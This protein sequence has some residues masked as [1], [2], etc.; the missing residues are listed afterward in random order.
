MHHAALL[1]GQASWWAPPHTVFVPLPGAGPDRPWRQL[2]L[3]V[4]VGALS[5]ILVM[6]GV[7]SGLDAC[8]AIG[9][10]GLVIAAVAAL[11]GLASLSAVTSAARAARRISGDLGATFF[12][13]ND[14]D[15]LLRQAT[16][17]AIASQG[18][19]DSAGILQRRWLRAFQRLPRPVP[20]LLAERFRAAVRRPQGEPEGPLLQA[21]G[22][23]GTLVGGMAAG[24]LVLVPASLIF[25]VSMGAGGGAGA[26]IAGAVVALAPLLIGVGLLAG[27]LLS[28]V[29]GAG[30]VRSL[31][32]ITGGSMRIHADAVEDRRGRRWSPRDSILVIEPMTDSGKA[33]TARFV[34]P[35]GH[36]RFRLGSAASAETGRLLEAWSRWCASA[37]TEADALV[38]ARPPGAEDD[39]SIS[40]AERWLAGGVGARR[41]EEELPAAVA[42]GA[43]RDGVDDREVITATLPLLRPLGSGPLVR[44]FA[45]LMS[46]QVAVIVVMFLINP[47][48]LFTFGALCFPA[49]MLLSPTIVAV[50]RFV[51]AERDRLAGA[52]AARRILA[53]PTSDPASRAIAA[54]LESTPTF[55]SNR[56]ES[57]R[58]AR[59]IGA[60]AP[61]PVAIVAPALALHVRQ[62]GRTERF[63]EPHAIQPG[64]A[65]GQTLVGALITAASAGFFL[66][67]G[68]RWLA[69]VLGIAALASAVRLPFIWYRLP[70][71]RSGRRSLLVGPGWAR[72]P[73]GHVWTVRD[74]TMIIAPATDRGGI[75]ARLVGSAGVRDV[76]FA[77]AAD[78]EF[79]AL[80]RL[81][82]HLDPR[83]DLSAPQ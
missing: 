2:V 49:I 74:A 82:T 9:V 22:A 7:S 26:S 51:R 37:R 25:V 27:V 55:A 16:L 45:L 3:G 19:F 29:A 28:F 24:L 17:A 5:V 78:P 66:L 57:A 21:L 54:C 41:L 73:A 56:T 80:W 53:D 11:S 44:Q 68:I 15:A 40:A 62:L 72:D 39:E 50:A 59:T 10:G 32:R 13:S 33:A 31:G 46:M 47:M 83:P 76:A 6:I 77:T 60:I 81:W 61:R 36:R 30:W 69:I 42:P 64:A 70:M 23:G 48:L 79:T 71:A 38:A 12:G 67:V 1:P 58:W 75:F 34:G 65:G 4:A 35:A 18:P 8:T 14:P 20:A 43:W 52:K 63:L